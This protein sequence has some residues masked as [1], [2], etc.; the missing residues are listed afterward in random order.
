MWRLLW[1]SLFSV[2]L[3]TSFAPAQ[4]GATGTEKDDGFLDFGRFSRVSASFFVAPLV[5]T[6]GDG[7]SLFDVALETGIGGGITY[8]LFRNSERRQALLGLGMGVILN[9]REGK[10]FYDATPALML[11]VLNNRVGIGY[12]YFTGKQ[13]VEKNRHR[14][15]LSLGIALK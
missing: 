2:L 3:C 7:E 10:N 1:C 8:T 15:F 11:T 13:D 5:V 12:G 14:M 4:D 6:E 9:T